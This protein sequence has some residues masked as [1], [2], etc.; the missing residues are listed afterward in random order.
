MIRKRR[1][2]AKVFGL[3]LL[4]L[5]LSL[6]TAQLLL[7][8]DVFTSD[9]H[10]KTGLN[11]DSCH[12]AAKVAAGAEVSMAKCMSCHGPYEKL[13]KRTE[14]RPSTRIQIRIT[15]ISTAMC[16]TTDTALTK[17]I[18]AVV[19]KNKVS[20]G[21]LYDGLCRGDRAHR[22]LRDFT[23][24]RSEGETVESR[25]ALRHYHGI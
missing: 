24:S 22:D 4:L 25:K 12:G 20:K 19:T 17:T 1:M 15:E 11:C 23:S 16:A 6:F 9:K 18:A 21:F 13:A 8:A 2:F 5:L 7:A 14:K 10:I 3:L